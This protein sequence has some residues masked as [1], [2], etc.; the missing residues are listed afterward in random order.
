MSKTLRREKFNKNNLFFLKKLFLCSM[1]SYQ[2]SIIKNFGFHKLKHMNKTWYPKR[3][4]YRFT[5]DLSFRYVRCRIF[6]KCISTKLFRIESITKHV[7]IA[8]T[9][10]DHLKVQKQVWTRT[11]PVFTEPVF[12]IYF[13]KTV[14]VPDF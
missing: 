4:I 1:S 7:L 3:Q 10:F 13:T 6:E 5:F 8:R 9:Q 2:L 12:R 14:L 11:G